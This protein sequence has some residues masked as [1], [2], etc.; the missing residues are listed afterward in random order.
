MSHEETL[1]LSCLDIATW[2]R[3]EVGWIAPEGFR[4][5]VSATTGKGY[6]S[7]AAYGTTKRCLSIIHWLTAVHRNRVRVAASLV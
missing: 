2:S 6:E 1:G 3:G 4:I 7:L 5:A